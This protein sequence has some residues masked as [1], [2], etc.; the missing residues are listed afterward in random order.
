MTHKP[1]HHKLISILKA[2][3]RV[4]LS[5]SF[6]SVFYE[7]STSHIHYVG[8]LAIFRKICALKYLM[9]LLDL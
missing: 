7:W 4:Q 3:T 1:N 5:N 2:K 6:D 8:L 9:A